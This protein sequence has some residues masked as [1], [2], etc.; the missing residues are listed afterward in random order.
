GLIAFTDKIEK[1]VPPRKGLRHALRIVRE[2]LYLQ[3]KGRKTDISSALEYLNKVSKRRAVC[4]V[5]SDF[6][7]DGFEKLLSIANRRHDI[8]AITITDPK[9][10]DL[11]EVGMINLKDPET[12]REFLVDTSSPV[13]R[14]NFKENALRIFNERDHLFRRINVDKIEIRTDVPY[15][16]TLYAFFRM[17][18]RRARALK[19]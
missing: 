10:I 19:A 15:S 14:K 5:L 7:E 11:P 9:E 6:Y 8:T 13:V 2:A 17:R 18:E 4:F 1:F 3:P 12:E 16:Q